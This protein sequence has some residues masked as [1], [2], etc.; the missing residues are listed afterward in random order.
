MGA[1]IFFALGSSLHWAGPVHVNCMNV[2][3]MAE[4]GYYESPYRGFSLESVNL[5]GII[6]TSSCGLLHPSMTFFSSSFS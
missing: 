6:V 1:K 3:N 4:V 5:H 2:P